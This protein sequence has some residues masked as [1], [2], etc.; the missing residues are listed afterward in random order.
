MNKLILFSQ[1]TLS[2]MMERN[3]SNPEFLEMEK[4]FE[5]FMADLDMFIESNKIK[6]L[7]VEQEES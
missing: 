2:F 7:T 4:K 3:T 5:V 6:G 1:V